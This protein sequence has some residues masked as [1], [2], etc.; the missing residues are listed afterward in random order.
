LLLQ[1]IY[2]ANDGGRF[3]NL[4]ETMGSEGVATYDG[5]QAPG[6]NPFAVGFTAVGAMVWQTGAPV[7]ATFVNSTLNEV[8]QQSSGLQLMHR[9]SHVL[10]YLRPM[11]EFLSQFL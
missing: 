4:N 3:V 6:G 1:V 11:Q 9:S 2:N 10:Q 5:S 8:G 7:V